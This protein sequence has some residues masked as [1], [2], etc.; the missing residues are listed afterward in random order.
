MKNAIKRMIQFVLRKSKV[1]S[2]L[3]G[4]NKGLKLYFSDDLNLDMVLGFHEPNT[5]EVFDMFIKEGMTVVDIGANVGYFTRC[6]S[7]K[8]GTKG[9]VYAFEPIPATF[10]SLQATISLNNISNVIAVNKASSDH[11]GTVTMYLSL[12]HYM[13]SLDVNWASRKGRNGSSCITL[14]S[15]FETTGKAPDFIKM[16]IEGGGVYA[17]KGM[18]NIIR[19]HEPFC[20]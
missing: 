7:K 11:N 20:F 5:F 19:K 18:Y 4:K 3:F 8:V 16:D 10:K 15:F 14:D 9:F 2:V 12:K 1:N 6:L 17:L 13:A